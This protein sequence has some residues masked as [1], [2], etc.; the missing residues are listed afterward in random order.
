MDCNT[1]FSL[2]IRFGCKDSRVVKVITPKSLRVTRRESDLRA[3]SGQGVF[4]C[5]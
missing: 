2:K 4:E 5:L 3:Q 1:R